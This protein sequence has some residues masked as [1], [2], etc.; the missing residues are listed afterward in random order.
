MFLSVRRQIF[1]FVCDNVC[2]A[3][4]EVN[5]STMQIL[6]ILRLYKVDVLLLALGVTL[7]TSLLKKTVLKNVSKKVYVLLPF[8]IGMIVFGGYYAI[9]AQNALSL[10]NVSTI[11]EGG[12]ACGSVATLY[13]VTYEQFFRKGKKIA[14][15]FLPL[16]EGYIPEQ[17]TEEA[18]KALLLT[19]NSAS[20]EELLDALQ[21]T[22][23][24]YVPESTTETELSA[25]AF[26]VAEYAKTLRAEQ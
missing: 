20:K 15:P 2:A 23:L 24:Q 25:L 17:K 13:Y 4:N 21:K 8:L 9:T 19:S 18:A 3:G 11:A 22:L 1:R 12:F 7:V 16:L 5:M 14:N 6:G 10:E 26:T